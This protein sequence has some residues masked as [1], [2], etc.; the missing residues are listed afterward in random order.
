MKI[1]PTEYKCKA[2]L[3]LGIFNK[4]MSP[5]KDIDIEEF[6]N[7]FVGENLLD[8]AEV[9]I[10]VF[11]KKQKG[12]KII[13]KGNLL[14]LVT[15]VFLV[16]LFD[17][18]RIPLT[19]EKEAHENTSIFYA[20]GLKEHRE[21]NYLIMDNFKFISKEKMFN[22]TSIYRNWRFVDNALHECIKLYSDANN[23]KNFSVKTFLY[24]ALSD[25]SDKHTPFVDK[26]Y[27]DPKKADISL[28]MLDI[29]CKLTSKPK[30]TF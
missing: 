5:R 21:Y 29:F 20:M 17:C 1:K 16:D 18:L 23:I 24:T 3:S 30:K 25:Y 13:W 11:E 14:D 22:R 26:L 10:M 8:N 27:N 15:F 2:E 28:K 19:L 4:F 9:M 6:A 12:E 7:A